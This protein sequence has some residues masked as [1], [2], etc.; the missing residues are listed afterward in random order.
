MANE[1]ST[2]GFA[3]GY[4]PEASAG[5]RPTTAYTKI[6]NVYSISEI[7][8]EPATYDVTDLSDLEWKRSIPALKDE[9]GNISLG[10]H[11]NPTFRTAW[12]SLVTAYQ[13]AASA[14]KAM[15]F[16]VLPLNDT[17]GFFFE[18]VPISLGLPGIETDSVFEGDV[19]ITVGK[20]E[21][22]QTKAT[23]S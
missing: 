4:C 18:G 14:N 17:H 2:V 9:V 15:W 1:M 8:P 21:A 7:N 11:L 6:P 12:G 19:Y 23:I 16:E 10:V 5:T 3:I 22:W 20:I 13:S